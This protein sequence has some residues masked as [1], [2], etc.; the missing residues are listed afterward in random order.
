MH[1]DIMRSKLGEFDCPQ[2]KTEWEEIS[3][4]DF[5]ISPAPCCDRVYWNKDGQSEIF[6][7]TSNTNEEYPIYQSNENSSMLM[8]WMWHGSIGHWVMNSTPGKHG[9]G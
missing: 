7:A 8:W 1:K 2:H 5:E 4:S 9:Q 3:Q 6:T